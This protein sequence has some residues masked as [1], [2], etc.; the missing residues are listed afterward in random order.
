MFERYLQEIGLNEK[1][2]NVY[3]TLLGFE[4]A[5]VLDLSKKCGM[6]RP[7]VYVTLDTLSKKGLVS[8][9]ILGKKTHYYAETPEKLETFIERKKTSLDESKRIL[10][11]I[12]PQLKSLSREGGERPIVKFFDGKEGVMSATEETMLSLTNDSGQPIYFIYSKDLLDE[13]FTEKELHELRQKRIDKKVKSQTLYTYK[14]SE[15][16]SDESANRVKID[17]E[18]YPITCD[19]AIYKDTVRISVLKKKVS[20]IFIKNQDVAETLKSLF[21]LIYDSKKN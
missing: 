21:R 14:Q 10:R 19:I 15:L 6:K 20:S 5:S 1:E 3:L 7:T 4:N 17:G 11:D 9:V 18:K 2:A 8:E 13:L 12:I 16:S